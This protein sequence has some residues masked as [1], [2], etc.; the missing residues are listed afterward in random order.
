MRRA[1]ETRDRNSPLVA[2]GRIHSDASFR[3]RN[4]LHWTTHVQH[5]RVVLTHKALVLNAPARQIGRQRVV[6]EI[7]RRL[8]EVAR[9]RASANNPGIV[10]IE[11][12]SRDRYARS[13]AVEDLRRRD[14]E[15]A[16]I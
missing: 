4:V 1:T 14:A 8:D 5:A 2:N 12:R 6:P 15:R 11:L 16:W 9:Q 13:N 10:V 3:V 7:D